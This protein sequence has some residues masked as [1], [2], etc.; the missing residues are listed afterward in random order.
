MRRECLISVEKE[1]E[2]RRERERNTYVRE[3][4]RK[5]EK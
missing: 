2:K 4:D 5:K 3:E 1:R